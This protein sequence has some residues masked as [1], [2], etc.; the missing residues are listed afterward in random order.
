M[1]KLIKKVK[2][3]WIINVEDNDYDNP[4]RIQ[5][6]QE[7]DESCWND[8]DFQIKRKAEEKWF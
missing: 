1:K 8:V 4:E 5:D 2:G 3:K 7:Q 6:R